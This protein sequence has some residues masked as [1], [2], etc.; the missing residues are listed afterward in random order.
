MADAP[1][2]ARRGQL[3]RLFARLGAA[4]LLRLT[5]ITRDRAEAE[6]WLDHLGASLDGVVAKRID[7]P[8]GERAMLKVKNLRTADC[9]VGGFR[10]G[11]KSRVVGSLLLG[12]TTRP[13]GSIMSGS[14]RR[15]RRPTGPR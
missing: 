2:E 14:P 10:Y 5:Q 6:G 12:R 1:L 9:V 7:A 11:T 3:E 13:G 4:P 15:S 8:A